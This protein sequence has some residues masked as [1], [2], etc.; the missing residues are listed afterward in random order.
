VS[1]A[2]GQPA[3]AGAAIGAGDGPEVR[4]G[5][6]GLLGGSGALDGGA[7]APDAAEAY[8]QVSALVGRDAGAL[9][10]TLRRV[11]G[12]P[13]PDGARDEAWRWLAYVRVSRGLSPATAAR[14][15][16]V[17]GRF[18]VYCHGKG[19]DWRTLGPVEID[20]WQRH[21]AFARHNAEIWRATQLM[22][23]RNFYDWRARYRGGVNA[24]DG[25]QAPRFVRRRRRKYSRK[26]LNALFAACAGGDVLAKRDRTMLLFLL[27]TGARREECALLRMD[28]LELGE[29][30]GLVRFLGKGR[31]ERTVP[32]EGPILALLREWLLL[33]DQ[34]PH[35]DRN[36]VWVSLSSSGTGRPLTVNGVEHV[37]TRVA[38]RAGLAAWGAHRFRV[39]FA[40]SL[41]D[42]GHDIESI[43]RLLGHND[44]NTTRAYLDVSD[45]GQKVRMR[46]DLQADLLGLRPLMPRWMAKK[47]DQ[48]RDPN[49]APF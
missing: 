6:G 39:T 42:D 3:G 16:E 13:L 5:A 26:D 10:A 9:A 49:V 36:R 46:S 32:I 22:A 31:K 18:L 40:T 35:T 27:A 20:A 14:Y 24:T 48:P 8:R 1:A 28:Q 44:I 25:V 12:L 4:P 41:Y 15:L 23:L 37:V 47:L 43:A 2:S 17:L 21:L 7:V 45:R 30:S 38:R 34:I 19:L 11:Q 33:R 29:R